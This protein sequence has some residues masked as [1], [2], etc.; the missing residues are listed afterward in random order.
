M[1]E[2]LIRR[3]TADDHR[4]KGAT[5]GDDLDLTH[6]PRDGGIVTVAMRDGQHV[7]WYCFTGFS[8][9][10]PRLRRQEVQL[11]FTRILLHAGCESKQ[12]RVSV[13][14]NIGRAREIQVKRGLRNVAE[15]TQRIAA[16]AVAGAKKIVLG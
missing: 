11:G 4:A 1:T 6:S 15:A 8:E 3:E 9:D 14:A 2:L 5:F 16:A 7:C 10:V 13:S 12:A